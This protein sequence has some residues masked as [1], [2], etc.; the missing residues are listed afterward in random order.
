VIDSCFENRLHDCVICS[1]NTW[2]RHA[3][4]NATLLVSSPDLYHDLVEAVIMTCQRCDKLCFGGRAC[5]D[6]CPVYR[7]QNTLQKARGEG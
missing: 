1:V 2:L 4:Y 6:S 5:P 3:K 7:W